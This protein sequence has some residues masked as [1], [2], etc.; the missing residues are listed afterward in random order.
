MNVSTR[1]LTPP[2]RCRDPGEDKRPTAERARRMDE[3]M[4]AR[5]WLAFLALAIVWGLPYLLIKVALGGIA[6]LEVAWWELTIGAAVLLPLAAARG[7]LGQLRQHWKP[8]GALA[9][10]QL[11][12]PSSLLPISEQWI[13]SS[14]AGVL[15]ATTPMLIALLGPLFGA[16]ERF[17]LRR[18]AGLLAGFL[19]VVVLLGFDAPRSSLEWIGVACMLLAALAYALAPLVIQHFLHGAESLKAS[20]VS[21]A[22]AALVLSPAGLRFLPPSLPSAGAIA[23]LIALGAVCTASG[24]LL[25]FFLIREAGAA[26]AGVVK[27]VS[28]VVA[29]LLGAMVLGEAFPLS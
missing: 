12:V 25:Y 16:Q 21:L 7:E 29:A 1:I 15:A 10:L 9:L 27:Y 14:L 24:M 3:K 18:T 8:I 5:A 2:R 28:P 23:C 17:D 6:A 13:R 4:N 26:R 20:A 11:A 19:G 22:I